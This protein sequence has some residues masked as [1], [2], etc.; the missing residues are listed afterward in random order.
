MERRQMLFDLKLTKTDLL[1]MVLLSILFFGIA[2]TSLG[3]LNY[4]V[5]DWQTTTNASFYVDFGSTQQV[6]NVY[7]WVKS[8]NA[9]AAVYQGSPD[10]WA[11]VGNY[12]LQS[13]AT[14]YSVQPQLDVTAT[15]QYLRFDV[16]AVTYDSRP[17]FSTW[18]VTNPGDKEPSPYIEVSEI[19]VES[20]NHTQIPITTVTAISGD[21]TN[22]SALAD[23]QGSL[24]IQPTYMS[25][26]YFDEVYFARAAEDYVH[27]E[28]PKERTHPPLGKE[29]Q[30]LG[31]LA[32]GETPFGWRIM[33][34]IFATLLIPLMYLIGKK[35]FGS[36]IGAFSAAFL[37]SFDFM[38]FTMARIGTVDT[39]VVFFSLMTQLFFLIYFS[40]VLKEGWKTH[41]WPLVLAV[42]FAAL[43]FSTK[44]FSLFGVLGML[45]LLVALRLREV[46]NLK[47]TLTEKYVAVFNHPFLLLI[48]LVGV[49]A[50]IYFA[51]YIPEMLIGD[52]PV[53]IWNLQNAMFSFHAGSV[54]DSSSAP[55]WTW[56]IM[57]SPTGLQV[58]K[59]FDI[60]YLPNN[61]VSTI[62]SFG[63][64]AVW[65]VGFAT[66]VLLIVKAFRIDEYIAKLVSKPK[67]ESPEATTAPIK[68]ARRWDPA[69]LFIVVV[70]LFS[71]LIYIFIGRATYIYHFYL[72]V[73]L[74]CFALAY[75]INKIWSKTWGKA[76]TI[77]LFVAVVALFA[78]FYPVISGVPVSSDYVHNLKWFPSWFFAP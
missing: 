6:Q 24:E 44:W 68:V 52:S 37:F 4:P 67:T 25:K 75:F 54:V 74:L 11:Y 46:K 18:G 14:D 28:I 57:A 35:L 72:S 45:A 47:A 64:P 16:K 60:T 21:T 43:G 50:A 30:A 70:F 77:A 78:V 65:W 15:T 59:W 42:V 40:R 34:V 10:N 17:D 51:T 58:P 5:T 22:I 20:T 26:M 32:F 7:F 13:R 1:T 19:G 3:E 69:A 8:G 66:M 76:L 61:T 31:V 49:F 39:Y 2:S 36:W 9:S 55:W 23:E 62:T 73:P 41:V 12:S 53:T 27:H 63:N 56:P 38:H 29:I 71:W 48:G 33:G